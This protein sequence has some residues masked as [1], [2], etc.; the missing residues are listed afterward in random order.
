MASHWFE[1]GLK[2][3]IHVVELHNIMPPKTPTFFNNMLHKWWFQTDAAAKTWN[4]V[5]LAVDAVKL[6]GLAKSI[7]ERRIKQVE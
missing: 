3:G 4:K 5:V 6:S 7:Y 1:F 2:L